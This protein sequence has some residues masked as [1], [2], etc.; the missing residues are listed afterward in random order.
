MKRW[1]RSALATVATLAA[2]VL[3]APAAHAAVHIPDCGGENQRVCK[4]TDQEYYDTGLGSCEYDLKESGGVCVNDK[5]R[6]WSGRDAWLEWALKQQ[7]YGISVNEPINWVPHIGGHNAY[8]SRNQGF[9][10]D[11]S[12][13]TYS[14]TDQLR[15]GVR[16]LELDP[17]YSEGQYVVCHNGIQPC[18]PSYRRRLA[19]VFDEIRNWLRDNPD[20]VLFIKLDEHVGDNTAGL[21]ELINH[22]FGSTVYKRASDPKQWPTVAQVRAAGKQVLLATRN[23]QISS[24][25]YMWYFDYNYATGRDHPKVFDLSVCT[26]GDGRATYA[27]PKWMWSA[28]AEG[29]SASN[30]FEVTGLIPTGQA[31]AAYLRC[32]VSVVG[33]DYLDALSDSAVIYFRSYDK[34]DRVGGSVWTF[35]AGD[36]GRAG[37]VMM[38]GNT[39]RWASRPAGEPRRFAC[40]LVDASQD[41]QSRGFRVTQ[42]ADVWT[43]GDETCK[44]EFG[45]AFRFAVP[46]LPHINDVVARAAGGSDVWLNYTVVAQRDPIALPGSLLFSTP[47]GVPATDQREVT[48]YGRTDQPRVL[49]A[50]ADVDWLRLTWTDGTAVREQ[51]NRLVLSVGANAP[52]A[53]GEYK[54]TLSVAYQGGAGNVSDIPVVYRILPEVLMS[55]SPARPTVRQPAETTVTVQLT[56]REPKLPVTGGAVTLRE[57]LT[58]PTADQ[59]ATYRELGSSNVPG[60]GPEVKLPFVLRSSSFSQGTHQL[61]AEYSGGPTYLA[62][63]TALT[64][65]QVLPRIE[66]QPASVSF[67]LPPGGP[68]PAAQPLK[69]AG[70]S[71]AVKVGKLPSWAQAQQV[72]DSW[73]VGLN[74]AA[75]QLP[76]GR[77]VSSFVVSDGAPGENTVPLTLEVQPSASGL[78]VLYASSG[79]PRRSGAGEERFVPVSIVN[80]GPGAAVGVQITSVGVQVLNGSG[81]VSL[82]GS[83]PIALPSIAAGGSTTPELLLRWPTTATRIRLTLSLT[84]NDGSYATTTTLSLIR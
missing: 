84:A 28:V 60:S 48:V 47:V 13:Q 46:T 41:F 12:N 5:R 45:S 3:A 38:R 76:A 61:V 20:E 14:I 2:T 27:R 69:V 4:W 83:L 26:D 34:D 78:P 11:Q 18:L 44:R 17:H 19:Y 52:T 42:A 64:P 7:R 25:T 71:S 72:G 31:V 6:I 43:R 9:G 62:S 50:K 35:E 37:P 22:Y 16:F 70:T 80:N 23:A 58:P 21:G 55:I 63:R 73:R 8:S 30:F 1:M 33:L 51:G 79:G 54:G 82:R 75:L 59:P 36:Y 10:I 57:L 29:R 53:P 40:A 67:T 81:V 74:A 24:T 49:F 15:M 77:Y 56:A 68:L 65:L 39:G 32:G 66:V